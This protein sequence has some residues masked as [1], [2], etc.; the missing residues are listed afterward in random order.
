MGG[1]TADEL[2]DDSDDEKR[3]EKAEKAAE[4]KAGLRKRKRLQPTPRFPPRYPAVAY[5]S[6]QQQ[7]QQLQVRQPGPSGAR[8]AGPPSGMQPQRAVGPCFACGEMGHLRVYCS[9]ILA[10]DRRRSAWLVHYQ[11]SLSP[12]PRSQDWACDN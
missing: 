12:I 5:P 6:Q 11:R 9:K 7:Q 4:R 8:R 3:L 2:A 10:Q 1:Y